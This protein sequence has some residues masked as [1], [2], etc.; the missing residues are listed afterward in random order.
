[1]ENRKWKEN[2]AAVM[3]CE[4]DTIMKGKYNNDASSDISNN[5]SNKI[6]YI[7]CYWTVEK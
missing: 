6:L 7:T 3:D 2:F 5:N 4:Q 1:M